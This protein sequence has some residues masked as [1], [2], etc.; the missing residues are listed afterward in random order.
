MRN[1]ITYIF[2]LLLISCKSSNIVLVRNEKLDVNSLYSLKNSE[3]KN[4]SI[5]KD[6]HGCTRI[7][8]KNSGTNYNYCINKKY[9]ETGKV[10]E[11]T[12][13]ET[14]IY[15]SIYEGFNCE[16]IEVRKYNSLGNLLEE[17]KSL[18]KINE[19][20]FGEIYFLIER[21]YFNNGNLYNAKKYEFSK[22]LLDVFK[23]ALILYMSNNLGK[24]VYYPPK[25]N[26]YTGYNLEFENNILSLKK[27]L[28]IIK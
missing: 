8:L 11:N 19:L 16:L 15:N 14:K 21:K 5:Q 23:H 27:Q 9:D 2:I 6:N 25:L 3:N 22:S 13:S 28:Q 1:I 12:F 26:N 10:I 18:S 4:Y 17:E 24:E 20:P 7:F